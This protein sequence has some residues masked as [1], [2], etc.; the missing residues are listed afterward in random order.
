MNRATL[1]W[2]AACSTALCALI[3]HGAAQAQTTGSTVTLYGS[4]DQY[5]NHMSS[6]SGKSFTSLQ[7]GAYMRS[8]LGFR[9]DEALGDD[10]RVKFQ[11]EH[12]LSADTGATA[13]SDKF[14]DRQAW[15]GMASKTWGELRL[16]RQNTAAFT[17]GGNVD[18]T[19]RTL[20]SM[21]NNFGL[22]ARL[23]NDLMWASPL[24]QGLQLELHFAPGES[25]TGSSTSQAVYQ[26]AVDYTAGPF[27]ANYAGVRAKPA[28]GAA[29]SQSVAYDNVNAN[30]D[31]GNGKV[32]LAL[33]RSNNIAA[34]ANGN[35]AGS[36]LTPVGGLVSGAADPSRYYN[37]VQLSADWRVTPQWRVG[38]LWGQIDD[39]SD[40]ARGATGGAIGSYFDLSKRTMLYALAE[41]LKNEANAGFRPAGSA[42][43]SPNFT[44]ADVNGQRIQGLQVG[45]LHRF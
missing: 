10:L 23:S 43:M 13:E 12:G 21:V 27:K 17:R 2:A 31:W 42:A 5:I 20:G 24:W 41:T 32:Y 44:G 11:L 25:T 33:V 34:N 35:T 22:P 15:V 9:G 19:A 16:G 4:V 36:L 8:R 6:S 39:T 37:I 14:F 3:A 30:C 40:S 45:V 29:Y 28:S 7:D 1:T 38:A 18:F 26:V